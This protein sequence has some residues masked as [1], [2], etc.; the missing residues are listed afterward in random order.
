M[1]SRYVVPYGFLLAYALYSVRCILEGYQVL[2]AIPIDSFQVGGTNI[3][4]VLAWA[5]C[6]LTTL[7]WFYKKFFQHSKKRLSAS[8]DNNYGEITDGEYQAYVYGGMCVAASVAVVLCN[9]IF[10]ATSWTNVNEACLVSYV[11]IQF[12][13]NVLM[14]GFRV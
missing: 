10:A 6:F 1:V 8:N 14:I 3:F 9:Y 13:A 5:L 12:G 11:F 7:W 2:L 4:A